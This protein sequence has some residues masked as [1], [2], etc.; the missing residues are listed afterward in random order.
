MLVLQLSPTLLHSPTVTI[1]VCKYENQI[2]KIGSDHR[3]LFVRLLSFF[4]SL[5]FSLF[6]Y[7]FLHCESVSAF[8]WVSYCKWCKLA[9]AVVYRQI[10]QCKQKCVMHIYRPA[11]LFCAP[12]SIPLSSFPS[13]Q[14][15][16]QIPNVIMQFVEKSVEYQQALEI[17]RK[18]WKKTRSKLK[19]EKQHHSS[20]VEHMLCNVRKI[21]RCARLFCVCFFV[22]TPLLLLLLILCSVVFIHENALLE[23]RTGT[24][25]PTTNSGSIAHFNF[26]MRSIATTESGFSF[27]SRCTHLSCTNTDFLLSCFFVSSSAL[28]PWLVPIKCRELFACPHTHEPGHSRA[29]HSFRYHFSLSVL[30]KCSH[31]T[32]KWFS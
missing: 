16:N 18:E 14:K 11:C 1:N 17:R 32:P 24:R 21:F 22:P 20:P 29:L 25:F 12:H 5:T 7:L 28:F 26:A 9:F 23:Q 15:P 19:R 27:Y 4:S 3:W 10:V 6:S 2:V 30:D 13:Q 31:R 8:P